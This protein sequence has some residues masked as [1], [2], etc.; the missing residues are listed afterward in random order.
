[1]A[2]EYPL[3]IGHC[4]RGHKRLRGINDV[5]HFIMKYGK[6]GDVNILQKNTI[7]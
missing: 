2:K 1:M 3:L 5:A 4:D 7:Q 6:Y